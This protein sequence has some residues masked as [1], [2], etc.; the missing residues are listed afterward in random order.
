[1]EP[2]K[3]VKQETAMI[4]ISFLVLKAHSSGSVKD[5]VDNSK[6]KQEVLWIRNKAV[7]MGIK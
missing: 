1:M 2:L 7:V 4:M 5:G 6:I 3:A